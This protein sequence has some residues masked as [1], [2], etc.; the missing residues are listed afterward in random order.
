MWAQPGV[1]RTHNTGLGPCL[2]LPLAWSTQ[3]PSTKLGRQL[4]G[5]IRASRGSS[6]ETHFQPLQQVQFGKEK[7]KALGGITE[8]VPARGRVFAAFH[9]AHG[10][11]TPTVGK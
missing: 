11:L 5:S 4:A 6:I 1:Q 10:S 8:H 9:E 2:M 7:K 3:S